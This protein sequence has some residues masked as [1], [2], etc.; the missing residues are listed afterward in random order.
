MS[1]SCVN[2]QPTKTEIM[3]TKYVESLIVVSY[4]VC[5]GQVLYNKQPQTSIMVQT[6]NLFKIKNS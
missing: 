6:K 4:C 1:H 2:D 3:K 5:F